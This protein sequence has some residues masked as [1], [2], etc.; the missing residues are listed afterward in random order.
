MDK[1]ERDPFYVLFIP[2][3]IIIAF[4]VGV[5]FGARII[6]PLY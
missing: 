4:I 5:L 2:F 3:A 1:P 6:L